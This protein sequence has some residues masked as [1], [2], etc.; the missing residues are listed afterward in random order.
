[1]LMPKKRPPN[2]FRCDM[3]YMPIEGADGIELESLRTSL[4]AVYN[5]VIKMPKS[6]FHLNQKLVKMYAVVITCYLI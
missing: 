5:D 6:N 2:K 4:N 3:N 1:M